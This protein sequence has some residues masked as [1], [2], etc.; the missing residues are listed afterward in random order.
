MPRDV[1]RPLLRRGSAVQI[2]PGA[3]NLFYSASSHLAGVQLPVQAAQATSS[4][5]RRPRRASSRPGPTLRR[6]LS[7]IPS[8][9]QSCIA[10]RAARRGSTFR[11]ACARHGP[12]QK[13]APFGF[14]RSRCP[15]GQWPR[16]PG[17]GSQWIRRNVKASVMGR[18]LRLPAASGAADASW[19]RQRAV[20][21][22]ARGFDA[23]GAEQLGEG[24]G[25]M[26]VCPARVTP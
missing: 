22:N 18:I 2:G 17:R 16:R 14:E 9:I 19:L 26:P 21:D 1:P 4:C 7:R 23:G 15:P 10:A 25:S 12:A 13:R 3:P 8:Q 20:Q 5:C 6:T 24:H 11:R